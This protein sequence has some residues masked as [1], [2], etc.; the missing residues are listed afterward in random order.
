MLNKLMKY[1]MQ[2]ILVILS[3]TDSIKKL[4]PSTRLFM[5]ISMMIKLDVEFPEHSIGLCVKA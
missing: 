3:V 1:G 2:E 5:V 4:K